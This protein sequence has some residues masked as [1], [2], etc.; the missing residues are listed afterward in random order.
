TPLRHSDAPLRH[1]GL[2]PESIAASSQSVPTILLDG[3]TGSGKTE[4]YLQAIGHALANG[5]SA[6]VLVPEIS[7]TPQTVARFKGRFG[8]KV[9]VIH[10]R[11]TPAERAYQWDLMRTGTASVAVGARSALFAPLNNLRLI[12]IDEEHEQTYKQGSTPRYVTRDAARMRA[13]LT[14]SVLVLGSATPSL[15]TLAAVRANRVRRIELPERAGAGRI[16]SVHV[17]NLAAEF[18]GGNKTMYSSVLADALVETIELHEKAVVL[19]NRRGF[20]SFLLCRDCGYVPTC[21]DCSVSLT[22]HASPPTLRCHQCGATYPVPVKCPQCGSMYL[23]KLGYGTEQAAMQLASLLPEGTPLIRMD[24]DTTRGRGGH[25]ARLQEFIKADYGVL[26]GTQMI[27]KGLDFPDVTL[28]G[29][30]LA[31]TS[32]NLPDFRAAERAYQL[33]EQ[34]SGRAGRGE[35]AGRVIVQTYWPEHP[36][37]RAAAAHDREILYARERDTR[38]EL[39]YPPYTRLANVLLWGKD[40]AAV[41]KHAMRLAGQLREALDGPHVDEGTPWRLM[42]PSPCVISKRQG[43]YRWHIL[44][45]APAG[46]DV[47]SVI[48][49]ITR[50]YKTKDDTRMA[51]DIDPY[52]LM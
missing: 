6:I 26:L 8:D 52:D 42:G 14:G 23:R 25:N 17:V 21:D 49:P 50:A 37:I 36:S 41:Q 32:L 28:V 44:I 11:M 46:A 38:N 1:S 30:L 35:L 3:V 39:G 27:A 5:G 18:Q 10:S 48:E 34:V 51:V 13:R 2:D 4:V 20:S 9:A 19:L 16:P 7:L 31:D 29:V 40:E 15:E 43:D 33:L 22:Y 24:A 47:P 12:I 45:K